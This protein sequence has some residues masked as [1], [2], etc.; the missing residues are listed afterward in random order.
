M[1]WLYTKTWQIPNEL[2]LEGERS[3]LYMQY[4]RGAEFTG[5]EWVRNGFSLIHQV[6]SGPHKK[7]SGND[8]I[9]PKHAES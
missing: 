4:A 3:K 8:V 2:F 5:N 1:A 6:A 7:C 9:S